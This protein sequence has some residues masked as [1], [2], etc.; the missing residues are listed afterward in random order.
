MSIESAVVIVPIYRDF[1]TPAE[2][3]SLSNTSAILSNWDMYALVPNRL[4]GW[5][6]QYRENNGFRFKICDF[7]DEFFIS[8]QSYNRL[9]LSR[10]FYEKFSDYDYMLLVQLDALVLRDELKYW[11]NKG[12]SYIGAPWFKGFERP[13]SPFAFMGVGNGG[14]SLRRISHFTKALKFPIYISNF[15]NN[16]IRNPLDLIALL[17]TMKSEFFFMRGREGYGIEYNEDVYWGQIAANNFAHIDIPSPAEAMKFSFE[18]MPEYLY[19]LNGFSLPF[20]C[21]AWEKYSPDFWRKFYFQS[22]LPY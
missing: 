20:G 18:V 16:L 6:E 4:V 21:H 7:P 8:T 22:D 11:C 19:R 14:F 15:I 2:K 3:Y 12:F 5:M 9:M 13:E 17:R 1:L 10:S